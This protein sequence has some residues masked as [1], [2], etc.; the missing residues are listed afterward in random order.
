MNMNELNT[1]RQRMDYARE[2]SAKVRSGS[3]EAIAELDQLRQGN[4]FHQ[5]WYLRTLL[6]GGPADGAYSF[7]S[8]TSRV[9]SY[10]ALNVVCRFGENNAITGVLKKLPFKLKK[11]GF[12]LLLKNKKQSAIDA[13][14]AS[15]VVDKKGVNLLPSA[16]HSSAR[17]STAHW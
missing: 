3:K 5:S 11:Q 9:L 15:G 8:S 7:V 4:K 2:L 14:F 6:V 12:I 13:Y 1:F 16:S 17:R 10:L